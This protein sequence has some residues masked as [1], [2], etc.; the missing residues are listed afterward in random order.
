[1]ASKIGSGSR[2][3]NLANQLHRAGAKNPA[4]LA[5]AIGRQKYGAARMAQL[6]AAGK[7]R[8]EREREREHDTPA[9]PARRVRV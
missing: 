3:R 5:A 6:A 2:S 9:R 1:M 7:R 4:A 8:A